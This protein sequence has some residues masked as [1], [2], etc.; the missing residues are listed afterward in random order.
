MVTRT[1]VAEDIE[2][3]RDVLKA[4]DDSRIKV[5]SAL[6]L[7]DSE[8]T[9]WQLVLALPAV[10]KSGPLDTY[11]KIRKALEKQHVD[12]PIWN[13]KVLRSTDDF[14]KLLRKAIKTPPDAIAGIRFRQN[15]IDNELIEDAYIYRS[16]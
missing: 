15:V 12:F 14:P 5:R 8:A 7:Y 11:R 10:N 13:I 2:K 3:G 6:W 9:S 1:L 16:A 4:L